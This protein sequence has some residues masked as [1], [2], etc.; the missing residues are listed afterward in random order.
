MLV[1]YP[2]TGTFLNLGSQPQWTQ[3]QLTG[4]FESTGLR[5]LV[6]LSEM[7]DRCPALLG[8]VSL[9]F[10]LSWGGCGW[11]GY[12]SGGW[13]TRNWVFL[14]LK[15]RSGWA[16]SSPLEQ[17]CMWQQRCLSWRR[18]K[19]AKKEKREEAERIPGCTRGSPSIADEAEI[20]LRPEL[21]AKLCGAAAPGSP[22]SSFQPVLTGTGRA[23]RA[24]SRAVSINQHFD[25]S[26]AEQPGTKLLKTRQLLM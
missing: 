19:K 24:P 6:A 20:R 9:D 17:T 8:K 4:W 11:A 23:P 16:L 26:W 10:G 15:K 14:T 1:W 21:E 25:K 12:F 3:P 5:G 13:G 2:D 7:G 22:S 18:K